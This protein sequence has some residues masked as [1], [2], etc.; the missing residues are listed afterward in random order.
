MLYRSYLVGIRKNMAQVSFPPCWIR[1][2]KETFDSRSIENLFNA[3]PHP[4]RC[5]CFRS[6]DWI[7]YFENKRSVY[8]VNCKR[9][10]HRIRV[11]SQSIPP[12][13]SVF[14]IAPFSLLSTDVAFSVV[15]KT[16]RRM[17]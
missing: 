7:E 4:C 14:L 17:S 2:I 13:L 12:L 8:F 1:L 3:L 11:V 6:P 9:S 5:F 16:H 15:S 10:N